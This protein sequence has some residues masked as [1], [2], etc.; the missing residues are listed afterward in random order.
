V[1]RTTGMEVC[2]G[3]MDR[4]GWSGGLKIKNDGLDIQRGGVYRLDELLSGGGGWG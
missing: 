4:M 2:I 3:K 1:N